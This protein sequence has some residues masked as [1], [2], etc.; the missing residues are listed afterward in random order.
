VSGLGEGSLRRGKE[1]SLSKQEPN[2]VKVG[3][4]GRSKNRGGTPKEVGKKGR[5]GSSTT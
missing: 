1:D 2:K 3:E 5:A 4:L